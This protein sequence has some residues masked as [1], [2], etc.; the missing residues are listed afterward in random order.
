VAKREKMA[1]LVIAYE[2]F[3]SVNPFRIA[4]VDKSVCLLVRADSGNCLG[5][6]RAIPVVRW[7]FWRLTWQVIL[8]QN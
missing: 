4:R 3:Y 5:S 7:K 6:T 1:D 2:P 8:F